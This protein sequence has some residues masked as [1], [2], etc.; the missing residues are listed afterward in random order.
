[1]RRKRHITCPSRGNDPAVSDVAMRAFWQFVHR[2]REFRIM[3]K[4]LMISGTAI[5]PN[6]RLKRTTD[7]ML[8]FKTNIWGSRR[9]IAE[10]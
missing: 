1:M 4:I 5:F 7:R 8:P 6:Q 2:K 10:I 3:R 9:L